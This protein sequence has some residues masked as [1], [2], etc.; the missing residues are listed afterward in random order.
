MAERLEIPRSTVHRYVQR[1]LDAGLIE[2]H[3]RHDFRTVIY[4][5]PAEIE[6]ALGKQSRPRSRPKKRA[7]HEPSVVEITWAERKMGLSEALKPRLTHSQYESL[8]KQRYS[9]GKFASLFSRN[10]ERAKTL[11]K[12]KDPRAYAATCARKGDEIP[13]P[14]SHEARC[15]TCREPS[16]ICLCEWGAER[17]RKDYLTGFEEYLEPE[18]DEDQDNLSRDRTRLFHGQAVH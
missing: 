8:N 15:P 10:L 16:N 7:A 3:G 9:S 17:R 1:L 12:I 5:I 11:P 13:E 18:P 4:T 2:S 14:D 6:Q